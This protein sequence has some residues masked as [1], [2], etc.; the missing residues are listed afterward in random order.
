MSKI[1]AHQFVGPVAARSKGRTWV[2]EECREPRLRR[3]GRI[4]HPVGLVEVPG[5]TKEHALKLE[6]VVL[7]SEETVSAE[8]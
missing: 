6:L 2:V 8:T 3:I 7:G 1:K 5:R 4:R